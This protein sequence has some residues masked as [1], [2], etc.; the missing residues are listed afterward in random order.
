M[1]VKLS[2]GHFVHH[3]LKDPAPMMK[4]RL[5]QMNHLRPPMGWIMHLRNIPAIDHGIAGPLL[6]G[7]GSGHHEL[8]LQKQLEAR[9]RND[10]RMLTWLE[11]IS[12]SPYLRPRDDGGFTWAYNVSDGI[13]DWSYEEWLDVWFGHHGAESAIE[14]REHVMEAIEERVDM[15]RVPWYGGLQEEKQAQHDVLA[16]CMVTEAWQS[17]GNMFRGI[18]RGLNGRVWVDSAH[19]VRVLGHSSLVWVLSR[20]GSPARGQEYGVRVHL[21]GTAYTPCIQ[22]V[23]KSVHGMD[24]LGAYILCLANDIQS[25]HLI[26]TLSNGLRKEQAMVRGLWKAAEEH[27]LVELRTLYRESA[28]QPP[29]WMATTKWMP[30]AAA[31]LDRVR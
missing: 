6:P 15:H 11:W 21:E 23:A 18:V 20:G 26:S 22:P 13:D 31:D 4:Q 24:L 10:M 17:S 2:P 25:S 30:L 1:T 9:A 7:R 3:W 29:S 28:P 5:P 14:L 16:R 19:R 12:M 8:N 27:H